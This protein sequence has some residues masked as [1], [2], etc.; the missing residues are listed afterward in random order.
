MMPHWPYYRDSTGTYH[1]DEILAKSNL[2]NDRPLFLSY[3]K[4]TNTVIESLVEH[5]TSKD[6]GAIVVV[7]SDHGFRY[8]KNTKPVEPF[9]FNNIC[10]VRFPNKNY[11]AYR[12]QWSAVNIF[13]YIFNAQY[14]QQF[15]YQKDSSILLS[16]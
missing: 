12:E 9:N 10:A 13:R 15:P 5:I 2:L 16:Y 11:P 7:M 6:P 8:Y 1:P 4:Y 14:G 3:L